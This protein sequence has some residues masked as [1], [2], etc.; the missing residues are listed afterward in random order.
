MRLATVPEAGRNES[1]GGVAVTRHQWGDFRCESRF[2][3]SDSARV[4][5]LVLVDGAFQTKESWGRLESEMLGFADVIRRGDGC[6]AD[7]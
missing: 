1:P 6:R 2:V 4:A 7:R 3:R 5:P